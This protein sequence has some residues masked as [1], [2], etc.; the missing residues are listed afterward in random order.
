MNVTH[1]KENS[2]CPWP[3]PVPYTESEAEQFFGRSQEV[4]RLL[5]LIERQQLNVLIALSGVG[6]SSLLQAGLVPAL[7][8]LREEGREFGPVLLIRDWARLHETSAAALVAQGIS[9]AIE[10]LVKR[11]AGAES[12]LRQDV[13]KLARVP[14]PV[15]KSLQGSTDAALGEL[16]GYVGQLCSATGSLVLILDQ[17]EELFGSGLS[18]PNRDLEEEALRIMGTLFQQEKK[19]KILLS[20]REEY[21]GRINRLARDVDGLDRRIFRLDPMPQETA[22][23]ILLKAGEITGSTVAFESE[24]VART[25]LSWLIGADEDP[26][27]I[28][29]QKPVDLLR[30]QAL[31]VGIFHF[32]AAA[33]HDSA[34]LIDEDLL[35]SFKEAFEKR[36]GRKLRPRELARQALENHIER[37]LDEAETTEPPKGPGRKLM[38]RTLV[39]MAPWLS[40]P[41]GFKRHIAAEELIFNAIRDDLEALNPSGRPELIRSEILRLFQAR[42]GN[43][44]VTMHKSEQSFLSGDARAHRWEPREAATMLVR[45]ALEVLDLLCL[46][47][48]LKP[49]QGRSTI[50][51]ELVHDGLGPALFEWAER[52]RLRLADTLASIVSRRGETFRWHEIEDRT[53]EEVSWLGCNLE[54]VVIRRT[55]FVRC[56]LTGAVFFGCSFEDCVFEDCDL[57]G[58]V[59]RQGSWKNVRWVSC[60]ADSSL[61]QASDWEQVRIE[62]SVVDNSTWVALRL[63]GTLEIE[64]S[65]LQFAQIGR[66]KIEG[67][68]TF[69]FRIRG[70]DLQ[71]A[72]LEER[73]VE[74]D[75]ESNE[76]GMVRR[77]SRPIAPRRGALSKEGDQ[78][79]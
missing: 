38:K 44:G 37:L 23:D 49:S 55:Q 35:A 11:T 71:N 78:A 59:F 52:E 8:Y 50:M 60:R 79:E 16:V 9:N 53:L 19:L 61:F 13:R 21:L 64:D 20:L 74:V 28:D 56:D 5:D 70:S 68:G 29:I 30:L 73:H 76:N 66:L 45:A 12:R 18:E 43:F 39:R 3:G 46:R 25:I 33:E 77:R 69:T 27:S 62:S 72:L 6:K 32:A 41:G 36:A 63:V 24:E 7:R 31:L 14:C 26:L 17:A 40:S 57:R 51:Y 34:I 65:S 42:Q 15:F 4:L 58:S 47:Y 1:S 54:D 48:V 67:D 2:V 10:D 75:E 22:K